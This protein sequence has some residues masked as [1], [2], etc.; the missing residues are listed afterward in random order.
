[1]DTGIKLYQS[2]NGD[3][4]RKHP[5]FFVVKFFVAGLI[6]QKQLEPHFEEVKA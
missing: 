5:S 2:L 1:M 6:E 4:S 3:V